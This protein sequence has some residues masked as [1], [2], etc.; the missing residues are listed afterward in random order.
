V[1]EC[2]AET[3][4]L[5]EAHLGQLDKLA[6]TLLEQETLTGEEVDQIM[7]EYQHPGQPEQPVQP[8]QPTG[9]EEDELRQEDQPE[10]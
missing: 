8:E 3:R 6:T 7:R 1:E 4:A 5:L 10:E 9:E 2:Y